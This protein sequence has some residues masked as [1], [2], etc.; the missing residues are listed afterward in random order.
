MTSTQPTTA[1]G[2][3]PMPGGATHFEIGGRVRD[4][5]VTWHHVL[6]P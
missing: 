2:E 1:A 5:E 6:V 3:L 4:A